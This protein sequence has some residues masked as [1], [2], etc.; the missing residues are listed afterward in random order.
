MTMTNTY[1]I[2][3]IS[4]L[5]SCFFANLLFFHVVS[6]LFKP[7][8]NKILSKIIAALIQ[9]A[10]LMLCNN[11]SNEPLA[12]ILA[13]ITY[14]II[15]MAFFSTTFQNATFMATFISLHTMCLKSIIVGS[16]SLALGKNMYRILQIE[17]WN[18]IVLFITGILTL[19]VIQGYRHEF[20]AEGIRNFFISSD[21][22]RSMQYGHLAL[23]VFLLFNS[24]NFYYNL[25]LLWFSFAQIFI[26]ILLLIIYILL[27]SYGL[28]TSHLLQIEL[29]QKQHETHMTAQLAQ[30][31]SLTSISDQISYFKHGYREMIISL[32]YLLEK[33]DVEQ[34]IKELNRVAP[35]LTLHL[36]SL[37]E[38][39]NSI[40][41]NSLFYEFK[42]IC[43]SLNIDFDAMLYMP[44][45]LPVP[46]ETFHLIIQSLMKCALELNEEFITTGKKLIHLESRSFNNWLTVKITNTYH[47]KGTLKQGVPHFS[48]KANENIYQ[49]LTFVK[50]QIE[51]K[52]GIITFLLKSSSTM[53]TTF[54]FHF[55]E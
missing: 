38:Y 35:E 53:E 17:N 49:E 23:Y 46:E 31:R 8:H 3:L 2:Y 20:N 1:L 28:R 4:T 6:V 41:C 33:G 36:P 5:L 29:R 19:F 14:V 34:A 26:G 18:L 12:S 9:T 48:S 30:Y 24:Y 54:S 47:K 10:I 11:L 7:R 32:Q 16:M 44:S 22:V 15:I 39:S 43:N 13:A 25:D 52:G 42:T 51:A 55:S 45:G 21:Q 40:L 27:M 37:K 50:N